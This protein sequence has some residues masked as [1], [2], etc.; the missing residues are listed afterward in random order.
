ML[1]ARSSFLLL[2]PRQLISWL[3]STFILALSLSSTTKEDVWFRK[4]AVYKVL[5]KEPGESTDSSFDWVRAICYRLVATTLPSSLL[6]WTM[7]I[8]QMIFKDST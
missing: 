4:S 8:Y 2:L 7:T 6:N 1:D 5:G 3:Q